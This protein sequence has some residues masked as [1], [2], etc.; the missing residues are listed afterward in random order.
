MS[1]YLSELE[2]RA[3]AHLI[4]TLA[5]LA[6][7]IM[8]GFAITWF[9]GVALVQLALIS[10]CIGCASLFGIFSCRTTR[11]MERA[12]RERWAGLRKEDL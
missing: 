3:G 9:P 8:S 5:L 6:I 11:L 4:A 12:D 2:R 7:A 10:I 1:P